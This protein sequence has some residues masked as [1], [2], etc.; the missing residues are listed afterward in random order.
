MRMSEILLV[1]EGRAAAK[2]GRLA[3]ALRESG[4]RQADAALVLGA[5]QATVSRWV[6]GERSPEREFAIRIAEL[7]RALETKAETG[8]VA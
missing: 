7:V 5:S 8:V 1:S 2:S 6:S 4:L 3:A